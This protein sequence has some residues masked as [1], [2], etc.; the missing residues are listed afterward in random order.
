MDHAYFV[1]RE[2]YYYKSQS[3]IPFTYGL[4]FFMSRLAQT[5][6]KD[7]KCFL[8]PVK[9]SSNE[10][11]INLTHQLGNINLKTYGFIK[12]YSIVEEVLSLTSSSHHDG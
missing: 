5:R 11:Y 9:E 10:K 3:Y 1:F 4:L 8:L 12:S 7:R 2:T 6:L